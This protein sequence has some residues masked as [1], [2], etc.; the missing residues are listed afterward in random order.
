M[1]RGTSG[2]SLVLG[3]N[4]PQGM[5]SHDVVNR[6]RRVFGERRV[7]HTGTLDPLATGALLVCVGPASRLD[8]YFVGHDKRYVVRVA[9]GMST[10]T[11][12]ALGEPLR[13]SAV[14]NSL[15]D[16]AAAEAFLR[17]LIGPSKQLPP[18]YSAIKQGGVKACDAARRGNVIELKP[19][20]IE[21]YAAR[22]LDISEPDDEDLLFWDV[23]FHVS[24]GTY[25]RSLA[26]DMGNAL[27][28]PAHVRQ[29]HRVQVGA[30][31]V[32][33]CVSLE[34]LESLGT[35]A[36]LDPVKLLDYRVI[37][38]DGDLVSR[39][40]SGA[41]FSADGMRICEYRHSGSLAAKCACTS[42]L[43]ESCSSPEDGEIFCV[44]SDGCL[45]ALYSYNAEK[46]RYCAACV[47]NVGV[48]R[49]AGI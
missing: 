29:L 4:K 28:C 16:R 26:R 34:E 22:L 45:M 43:M 5:S 46:N 32:D 3:I 27:G 17:T 47:F 9:F 11:D 39:V 48:S 21:V 25:I 15:R 38:A 33:E 13:V 42:G 30:L 20:D 1:K 35:R 24:K 2:L 40:R 44:V 8:A 10:D 41:A 14:P 36:A 12:D 31:D 23:E 7:G 49:G 37:F 19:R 18:V 6:C